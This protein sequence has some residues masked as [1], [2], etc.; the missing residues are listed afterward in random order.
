MHGFVPASG[1]SV[2]CA[3]EASS[4]L[5]SLRASSASP[6][7]M[8]RVGQTDTRDRRA[9][10]TTRAEQ[11]QAACSAAP[12]QNRRRQAARNRIR[13]CPTAWEIRR[14]RPRFRA[15]FAGDG[16]HA[17]GDVVERLIPGDG[18]PL[19]GAALAGA[20]ERGTQPV[21]I[22]VGADAARAARAKSTAAERVDGVAIDFPELAVT[23]G[24]E[25][26]ALPETDVAE[27]RD[28]PDTFGRFRRGLGDGAR[29]R[30]RGAGGEE[31]GGGNLEKTAA[32]E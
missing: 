4:R 9:G 2:W 10:G 13:S 26:V 27:R 15:V 18:L 16:L 28:A 29:G 23:D 25:G 30:A 8:Q 6:K 5:T 14:E 31:R 7:C 32:G 21:G 22:G 12:D 1:S 3:R 20:N 19:L 11:V 24:G 17:R